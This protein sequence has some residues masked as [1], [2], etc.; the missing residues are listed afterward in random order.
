MGAKSGYILELY[1]VIEVQQ[2]W[3]EIV[4]APDDDLVVETCSAPVMWKIKK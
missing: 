4:E 2:F 3:T 1:S